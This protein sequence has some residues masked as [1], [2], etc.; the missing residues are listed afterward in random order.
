MTEKEEK[1]FSY[2]AY[3]GLAITITSCWIAHQL[4]LV[5]SL[6]VMGGLS[7]YASFYLMSWV[8]LQRPDQVV[9]ARLVI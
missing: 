2:F 3:A 1:L 8:L 4:E 7:N 9:Y 5:T 6:E